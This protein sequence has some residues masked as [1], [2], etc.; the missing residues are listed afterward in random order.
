MAIWGDA[1]GDAYVTDSVPRLH[2]VDSGGRRL[3]VCR[4]VLNGAHGIYGTV[5]GDLFLAEGNPSR[6]TRLALLP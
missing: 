1:A 5:E 6:V 2:R 4:P 3:G